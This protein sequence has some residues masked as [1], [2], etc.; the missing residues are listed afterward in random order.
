MCICSTPVTDSYCLT[1]TAVK[2]HVLIRSDDSVIQIEQYLVACIC[3]I[4]KNSNKRLIWKTTAECC[5]FLSI[6][7]IC[8]F[9]GTWFKQ[10][11]INMPRGNSNHS[12]LDT[13]FVS[14]LTFKRRIKSHLA[15]AGIIRSSPY[16][17]GF[18]DKG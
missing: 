2:V 13:I 16:S 1:A 9:L 11:P 8:V 7:Q 6:V 15:F 17:T 18:Q 3:W 14:T 4:T 12:H 10:F 5:I